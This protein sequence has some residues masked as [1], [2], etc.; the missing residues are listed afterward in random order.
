M[1][2]VPGEKHPI[3]F[4]KETH[5]S[6]AVLDDSSMSN[7]NKKSI[8][9]WLSDDEN[10]EYLIACLSK[11]TPQFPMDLGLS[12]GETLTFFTKGNDVPVYI[13][14]YTMEK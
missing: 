6:A 4:V 10:A 11:Q 14:G 3:K 13:S 9:L 2:I 1:S 7:N 12:V 8:Q 5:I